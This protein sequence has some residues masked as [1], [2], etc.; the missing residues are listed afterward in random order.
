M[1]QDAH[2]DV[3]RWLGEGGPDGSDAAGDSDAVRAALIDRISTAKPLELPVLWAQAVKEFGE[4]A[5]RIWQ[6]ALSSRDASET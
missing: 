1:S 2:D 6:E 5:S 3:D 4:D